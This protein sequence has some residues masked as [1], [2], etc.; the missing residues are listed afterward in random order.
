MTAQLLQRAKILAGR[1]AQPLRLQLQNHLLNT[2]ASSQAALHLSSKAQ[3]KAG[4]GLAAVTS[5]LL[6]AV[7]PAVLKGHLLDF[8][9]GF[10]GL[11]D[12]CEGREP[13]DLQ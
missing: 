6:A 3:P 8:Q 9:V 4:E 1:D 10:V 5:L 12:S 7:E 2:C 13:P 11:W